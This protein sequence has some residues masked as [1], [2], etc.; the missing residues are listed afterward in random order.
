VFVA[1]ATF[2]LILAGALV[3]S[4]DA[5]LSIPDWPTSFGS[6]VK[7][8]HWAGGA[9]FE[10]SHRMIAGF[11][12]C[13]T[14]AIAA[15]TLLV[16]KRPWLRRLALA[17]FGTVLAQAVLLDSPFSCSSLQRCRPLMPRWPRPFSVS[18]C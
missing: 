3:T 7:V 8:P 16:D 5:G 4:N 11:V 6:L 2:V 17:A 13:L 9:R 12:T 14:L 10:W 18:P 15:W 1:C